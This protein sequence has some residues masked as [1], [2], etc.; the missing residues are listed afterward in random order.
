MI[1]YPGIFLYTSFI[2]IWQIHMYTMIYVKLC[3]STESRPKTNTAGSKTKRLDI[4]GNV[5]THRWESLHAPGSK[6]FVSLPAELVLGRLS[7]EPQSLTYIIVYIWICHIRMKLV[8]KN[9][10]GNII[11][12]L[13][14]G[15]QPWKK[16]KYFCTNKGWLNY[17]C[18]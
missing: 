13:T 14:Y 1:I 11:I 9:I 16:F 15:V 4:G 10:P 8:Y 6:R 2:W 12:P 17:T 18:P 5:A 3:G 7:V